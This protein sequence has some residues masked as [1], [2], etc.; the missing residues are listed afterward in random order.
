MAGRDP[1]HKY[2]LKT[3]GKDCNG[4]VAGR[5]PGQRD[6]VRGRGR[7]EEA[8]GA[9][10]RWRERGASNMTQRFSRSYMNMKE[11]GE[12][13][14]SRQEAWGAPPQQHPARPAGCCSPVPKAGQKREQKTDTPSP[15]DLEGKAFVNLVFLIFFFPPAGLMAVRAWLGRS[16]QRLAPSAASQAGRVAPLSPAVTPQGGQG[17]R[18][19]APQCSAL[20][21]RWGGPQGL[22]VASVPLGSAQHQHHPQ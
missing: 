1:G 15:Q 16:G 9:G 5:D 21:L 12:G 20:H 10:R 11:A 14:E 13:Q 2:P 4:G 18:P 8:Q 17:A 22:L 3:L 19:I 6:A 7:M